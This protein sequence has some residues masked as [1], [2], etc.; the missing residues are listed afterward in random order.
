MGNEK[1]Q[2]EE[3][4]ADASVEQANPGADIQAVPLVITPSRNYRNFS[5]FM[6]VH[7]EGIYDYTGGQ[8]LN[9]ETI[10][11]DGK[12]YTYQDALTESD[13]NVHIG[14]DAEASL[15]NLVA[16]INLS[17]GVPGTDYALAMTEHPTVIAVKRSAVLLAVIVKVHGV[18]TIAT[19][20]GTTNITVDGANVSSVAD[21][22]TITFALSPDGVNYFNHPTTTVFA[23]AGAVI[24]N[25]TESMQTIRLT[26]DGPE[27]VTTM[28]RGTQ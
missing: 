24:R 28:V 15:D 18:S 7:A 23:D 21:A 17:G 22:I 14:G 26:G 6:G 25:F 27:H 8:P 9:T 20:E 2:I 11:I 19:L 3:R 12:V 5:I 13:G 10:T 1:I 4:T 16:A